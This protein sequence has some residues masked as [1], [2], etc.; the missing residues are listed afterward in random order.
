[1]DVYTI[2]YE[3]S[4][5][6]LSAKC[7]VFSNLTSAKISLKAH[8]ESLVELYPQCK[9]DAW[10]SFYKNGEEAFGF[11]IEDGKDYYA[12]IEGNTVLPVKLTAREVLQLLDRRTIFSRMKASEFKRTGR[13]IA[14]TF[15]IEAKDA[16]CLMR[17]ENM[18]E[19]LTK[20]EN[21]KI[22]NTTES[23]PT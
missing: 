5:E 13:Q 7:K 1:M 19:I 23:K 11:T 22:D 16:L 8:L 20:Y 18:L 17:G 21:F 10:E 3:Q 14:E 6:P 12:H 9:N 15:G 2:I 4:N